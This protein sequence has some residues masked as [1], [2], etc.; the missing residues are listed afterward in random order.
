M[1]PEPEES[2][3][4][5]TTDTSCQDALASLA[6]PN[7]MLTSMTD[8]RITRH[9]SDFGEWESVYRAPDV[10]L[11]PYVRRLSGWW[12]R[13]AFARRREVPFPGAVLIINIENRLGVSRSRTAMSGRVRQPDRS[14][15]S[16]GSCGVGTAVKQLG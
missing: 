16:R 15:L 8:S 9:A 10:R 6:H 4:L 5:I 7:P 3:L 13:T 14:P 12:E 2:Q 1:H 11:A